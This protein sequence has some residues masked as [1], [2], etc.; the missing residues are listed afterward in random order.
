MDPLTDVD[1]HKMALGAFQA[2]GPIA[3]PAVSVLLTLL[4]DPDLRWVA[5]EALGKIGPDA[6]DAV[7]VLIPWLDDSE[8]AARFVA[9]EVLGNIGPPAS[10][11]A[12]ALIRHLNDTN[13]FARVRVRLALGKLRAQPDLVVPLLL[14]E[15]QGDFQR[16]RFTPGLYEALG[17][18]GIQA[19][20]AVPFLL[21]LAKTNPARRDPYFITPGEAIRNALQQID[22]AAAAKAGIK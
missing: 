4:H 19:Q 17:A 16:G 12:P 5:A 11:A 21:D 1:R 7:P 14:Q 15:M 3:K 10:N 6:R 8:L 13:Q 2:L 18:Y 22:P 9:T 20:A